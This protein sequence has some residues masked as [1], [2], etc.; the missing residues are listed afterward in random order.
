MTKSLEITTLSLG[1]L[2]T[3]CYIVVDPKEIETGNDLESD[4]P[5][6]SAWVIDPADSGDVIS[7]EILRNN[8]KLEKIILTHGHFDHILGLL[9]LKLNFP[10]AEITFTK[11]T[12]F[13]WKQPKRGPGTG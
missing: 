11:T 13:S 3:N 12:Y 8:L 9:E 5:L 4:Q 10:Q 7:E 6:R 2:D 1:S